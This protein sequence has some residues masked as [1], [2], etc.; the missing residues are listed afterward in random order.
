MAAGIV[1]AGGRRGRSR[2]GRQWAWRGH[3]LLSFR[4]GSVRPAGVPIGAGV[5]GGRVRFRP[6]RVR[7]A[8]NCAGVSGGGIGPGRGAGGV[9]GPSVSGGAGPVR[10]VVA[11]FCRVRV[12]IMGRRGAGR[13][14]RRAGGGV[15]PGG[16]AASGRVGFVGS[17]GRV[18]RLGAGVPAGSPGVLSGVANAACVRGVFARLAPCF[19]AFSGVNLLFFFLTRLTNIL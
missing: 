7:P 8:V 19:R 2:G 10:V 12:R 6:Q 11:L 3:G 16:R 15:R 4:A 13:R 1:C 17:G 14:S 9:S 18:G 5:P